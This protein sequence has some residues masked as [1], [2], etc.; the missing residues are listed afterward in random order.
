MYCPILSCHP[1]LYPLPAKAPLSVG[2]GPTYLPNPTLSFSLPI[3]A[4][5][6][7]H[8]SPFVL[9]LVCILF[10]FSLCNKNKMQTKHK[11][12]LIGKAKREVAWPMLS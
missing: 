12:N 6:S 11:V 8:P 9:H 3:S 2:Q 7:T 1:A 10:V 4:F 5:C